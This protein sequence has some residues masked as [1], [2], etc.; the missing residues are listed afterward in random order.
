MSDINAA[1]YISL[2]KSVV[3]NENTVSV[4]TNGAPD[5]RH[6][7]QGLTEL[8]KNESGYLDILPVQCINHT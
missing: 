5:M 6:T 7:T 2:Q 4:V 8:L 1:L 3:P